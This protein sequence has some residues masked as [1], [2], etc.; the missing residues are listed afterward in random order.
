[1]LRKTI[2]NS[3]TA[4]EKVSTP[5][6]EMAPDPGWEGRLQAAIGNDAMLLALAVD[7][8]SIDHKLAAVQALSGEDA[9]RT[10]ERE[11]RKHDRRVHSLAKQRYETLVRQ[12]ETRAVAAELI[13]AAA[14][15]AGLPM[16]PAN[17][18]VELNQAWELLDAALVADDQRAE[19]A[20]S[21]SSLAELMRGRAERK[22]SGSRWSAAGNQAL[23]DIGA[24]L[25]SVAVA[26][27]D[28]R[29]IGIRLAAAEESARSVLA[30]MPT[31]GDATGPEDPSIAMLA[32]TIR[33]ALDEA[34]LIDAR[35][36]VLGQLREGRSAQ[37]GGSNPEESV[38]PS[39]ASLKAV[40]EHWQGLPP[41]ADKYIEDALTLRF[42]EG[43]RRQEES[44]RKMQEEA[45]L[46][47][48]TIEKAKQQARFQALAEKVDAA[49]V[50]LAAGHLAE[51][52]KQLTAL[53]TALGKGG[54]SAAQQRR[55]GVLQAELARLKGWQ[56]W[57]G[58][59][60]RDDLVAEAEALAATTVVAEG[61]RPPKLAIKQLERDIEQLRG[62]WKELDRLGGA[63]SKPLWQR[64]DGAL[65]T[66]YLPVAA[67]LARLNEARQENLTARRN[68]LAALDVLDI[69]ANGLAA[70]PDWREVGRAL[71]H[72]QTEWRKLGPLEHTV[73][74]KVQPGL[75]ERMLA[76]VARLE[77]PLREVHVMA[78]AQ[79][80]QLIAR[81]K[82]LGQDA[83]SRD[84]MARLRELQSQWQSHAKSHPLPR[85]IENHLWTEFRAA[86][87]AL[88][89]MREAA[90]SARD[91]GLKANQAVR[92]ALIAGLEEL[93][94]D[95]P[96]GDIKRA[97]ARVETEW[98]KAG[99]A[100]KN[101]AAR[102]ESR[103]RAARD[104][105]LGHLAGSAQRT[106]NRTCDT[107][108]AKLALCTELEA[109]DPAMPV[110]LPE[111]QARWDEL[112]SLP[113]R[114]EQ[115]L[116]ARW[117]AAGASPTGAGEI[118]RGDA[119]DDLLLQLESALDVPSPEAFQMARR[120][121][122][123]LA[124]KTAMEGRR[125]ATP[126]PLDLDGM[127]A[128][129]FACTRLRADQAARLD[130]LIAALRRSGSGILRG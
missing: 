109:S 89:G 62:R 105:A 65:K 56:H 66:A 76:S 54:A 103:Y 37:T 43:L 64:F 77:A 122:K 117:R 17:R 69:D 46:R 101:Q 49:E 42:N 91:A 35:L 118:G 107:L 127:I 93:H 16:I 12:R 113:P 14:A 27:A 74:H 99:D 94:P 9:L 26:G 24:A 38:R 123:L 36:A 78:Q 80:E 8:S 41:L 33:S 50:A 63:T 70:A 29:E 58:G 126:E 102:L 121:L 20:S 88:I 53:Q 3:R 15:L 31:G 61:A 52:G 130:A 21:Q 79:R 28:P 110:A 34:T 97:L 40:T 120:T 45:R 100:P 60:V 30:A 114:W 90:F 111:V 68:L 39:A 1:M 25:S 83:Q 125:S 13:R 22:R 44:L 86:T 115:G 98:R 128:A 72:F 11:F 48:S 124:M 7:A 2:M 85:K 32:T 84:L 106:W 18:L 87:D 59:R 51:A 5:A 104:K 75:A 47:L 71:A 67:H 4:A 81:A 57:G 116:Q 73:P 19:F 6:D 82:A 55:I 119:A 96:A 95:T 23:A 92:E 10:A 129:A 108:L 112:P